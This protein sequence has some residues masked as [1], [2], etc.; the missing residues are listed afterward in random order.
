MRES[1]ETTKLRVVYYVSSKLT[2]NSVYLSDC[3]ETVPPLQNS[4][5]DILLRSRFKPILFC[6]NIE[7]VFLQIRIRECERNVLGFHWVNNVI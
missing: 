6:G 4:M 2:K 7:K 3:L 1:A 5:W